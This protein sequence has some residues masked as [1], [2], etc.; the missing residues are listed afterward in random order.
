MVSAFRI[1]PPGEGGVIHHFDED[2][3]S[4]ASLAQ[5]VRGLA[6][7]DGRNRVMSREA[8]LDILVLFKAPTDEPQREKTKT[9]LR[10]LM[11][12]S[13]VLSDQELSK[14]LSVAW[15]KCRTK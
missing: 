2:E 7:M 15:S 12:L 8:I 1:R 3:S 5:M 11:G 13:Y 9:V 4:V 14:M 6:T 10:T